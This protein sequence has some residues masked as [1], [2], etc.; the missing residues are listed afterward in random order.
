MTAFNIQVY[1]EE[2]MFLFL[3]ESYGLHLRA[4]FMANRKSSLDAF[5]V[6]NRI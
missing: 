5:V 3:T 6:S 2:H 4:T 1:L